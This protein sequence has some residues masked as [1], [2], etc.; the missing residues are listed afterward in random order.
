MDDPAD[1]PAI[2]HPARAR[3]VRWQVRF[4]RG[5]C[6]IVQPKKIRQLILQ[7]AHHPYRFTDYASNQEL[8]QVQTLIFEE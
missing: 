2:I 5:P 7:P 4:N 6:R 1:D 8:D 3:L